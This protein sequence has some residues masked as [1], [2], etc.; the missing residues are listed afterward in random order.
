MTIY[1]NYVSNIVYRNILEIKIE[2]ENYNIVDKFSNF[3]FKKYGFDI[4]VY[5]YDNSF[6]IELKNT[7]ITHVENSIIENLT[8]PPNTENIEII[9]D[10][11]FDPNISTIKLFNLSENICQLKISSSNILFDLSNLPSSLF[12]LD[13]S[14]CVNKLNL[15]Y[16]TEGLKILYLPNFAYIKKNNFDYIYNLS[17]FLNLPNSLI[18]INIGNLKFKSTNDLIKHLMK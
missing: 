17:D 5:A 8:F 16:L 1:I 12:L 2:F 6:Q 3:I 18:E 15:D 11:F 9:E 10:C 14:E 4:H 7:N 13:I